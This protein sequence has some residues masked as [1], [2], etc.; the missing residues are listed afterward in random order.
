MHDNNDDNTIL[1]I[2]QLMKC[3]IEKI[4]IRYEDDQLTYKTPISFGI[5]IQKMTID[6]ID[7]DYFEYLNSQ[8]EFLPNQLENKI[9]KYIYFFLCFE[10]IKKYLKK[11]RNKINL[12]KFE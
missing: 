4:H 9:R 7:V 12:K 5:L 10:L 2:L 3:S 1:E 11:I 6:S 8:A